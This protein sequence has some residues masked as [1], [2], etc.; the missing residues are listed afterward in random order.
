M[1]KVGSLEQLVEVELHLEALILEKGSDRAVH[2]VE[3]G[4]LGW[5]L[6]VGHAFDLFPVLGAEV[7][8]LFLKFLD[9]TRFEA[10]RTQPFRKDHEDL[11]GKNK[12]PV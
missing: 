8:P 6:G 2:L 1:G 9:R 3:I 5:F 7:S 10:T 11:V 4:P 12:K